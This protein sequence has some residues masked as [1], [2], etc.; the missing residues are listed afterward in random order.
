VSLRF[1]CEDRK[2]LRCRGDRFVLSGF[3]SL[4]CTSGYMLKSYKSSLAGMF[5]PVILNCGLDE[6]C[7]SDNAYSFIKS[8]V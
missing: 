4:N 6:P 8:P 3:S 1:S 2:A 5:L 7:S